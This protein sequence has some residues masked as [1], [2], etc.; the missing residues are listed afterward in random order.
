MRRDPLTIS[1]GNLTL[2]LYDSAP[3]MASPGPPAMEMNGAPVTAE[4]TINDV[5]IKYQNH[6][7][8]AGFSVSTVET[9]AKSLRY[10][11]KQT[12]DVAVGNRSLTQRVE[13]FIGQEYRDAKE[14]KSI[15]C[16]INA[17]RNFFAWLADDGVIAVNPVERIFP[18]TVRQDV[19]EVLSRSQEASYMKAAERKL[20]DMVFAIIALET[21]PK[22]GEI[23]QIKLADINVSNRFRPSIL[24]AR[25]SIRQRVMEL[26]EHFV[27][28]FNQYIVEDNP[29]GW[30]AAVNVFNLSRRGLN[31][32]CE[33]IGRRA[34]IPFKVHLSVLRETYIVKRVAAGKTVEAVLSKMK[35]APMTID[36]ETVE[37]YESAAQM[38]HYH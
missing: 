5:L 23:E 16:R 1:S 25:R 32:V 35:L 33:D 14:S 18:P 11:T 15:A 28:V 34:A 6:L 24:L 29:Q 12:G 38:Y 4:S 10:F 22:R 21:G 13:A 27:S 31:F 17:I 20:R 26:P 7:L 36:K 19:P 37:R 9:Y 30:P 2:P 8:T 3:A